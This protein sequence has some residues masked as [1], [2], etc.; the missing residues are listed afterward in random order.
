M[1]ARAWRRSESATEGLEYTTEGGWPA[2][3]GNLIRWLRANGCS[4]YARPLEEHAER[5][6]RLE[7]ERE[8]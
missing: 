1:S 4:E 3:V 7:N 8:R 6:Y 2:P 5:A